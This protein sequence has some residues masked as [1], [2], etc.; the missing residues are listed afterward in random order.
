MAVAKTK[1]KQAKGESRTKAETKGVNA[2][3]AR[4]SPR[5]RNFPPTATCC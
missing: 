5:N 4:S 1:P 2:P 3:A